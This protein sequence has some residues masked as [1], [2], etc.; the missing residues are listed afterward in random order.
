MH[1]VKVPVTAPVCVECEFWREND[2][3]V[4]RCPELSIWVQ[5]SGF[6]HVKRKMQEELSEHLLALL[7]SAVKHVDAA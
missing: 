4:G 7:R 6:E 3:W 2:S 5:G 1:A